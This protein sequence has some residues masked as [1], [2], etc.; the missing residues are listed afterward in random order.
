MIKAIV[1]MLVFIRCALIS[2]KNINIADCILLYGE[3]FQDGFFIECLSAFISMFLG[4]YG[5]YK[6]KD[7]KAYSIILTGSAYYDIASLSILFMLS[8][9]ED[10]SRMNALKESLT[11]PFISALL[12]LIVLPTAGII[13]AAK[14]YKPQKINNQS[15]T[16]H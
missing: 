9:A 2:I 4:A 6:A 5:I 16:E 7:S 14:H 8:I 3:A 15:C 11:L 10:T 12:V 13:F 1:I